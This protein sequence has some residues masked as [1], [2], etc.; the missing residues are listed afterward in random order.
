M[1][2]EALNNWFKRKEE[3]LDNLNIA[4]GTNSAMSRHLANNGFPA[5][6]L[7]SVREA[8]A[9]LCDAMQDFEMAVCIDALH[10]GKLLM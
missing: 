1:H 5:T 10:E 8:L 4:T 2:A 9:K 7:N 3:I 6:E